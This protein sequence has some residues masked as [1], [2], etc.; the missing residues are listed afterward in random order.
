MKPVNIKKSKKFKMKL[1]Q[2]RKYRYREMETESRL[3]KIRKWW[4]KLKFRDIRMT[5][6]R[7]ITR[8]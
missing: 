2:P 1:K 8:G 6:C 7:F 4:M 5:K 3:K